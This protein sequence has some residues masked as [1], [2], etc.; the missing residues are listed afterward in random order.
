[1]PSRDTNHMSIMLYCIFSFISLPQS[2]Q[3]TAFSNRCF[4]KNCWKP[5]MMPKQEAEHASAVRWIMHNFYISSAMTHLVNEQHNCPQTTDHKSL[6]LAHPWRH[7]ALLHTLRKWSRLSSPFNLCCISQ[8]V[9]FVFKASSS[10][11]FQPLLAPICC[12]PHCSHTV[13]LLSSLWHFSLCGKTGLLVVVV[14]L[15]DNHTVQYA[16]P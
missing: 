6:Y 7:Q 15:A 5:H 2:T 1:M 12:F 13:E 10:T 16:S 8:E 11:I 9:F 4:R 3:H 14:S